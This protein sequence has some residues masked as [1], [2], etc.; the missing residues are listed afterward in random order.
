MVGVFLD[1]IFKCIQ[2][3]EKNEI[4]RWDSLAFFYTVGEIMRFNILK[5]YEFMNC[6]NVWSF[7]SIRYES[8][9]SLQFRDKFKYRLIKL[10]SLS[11]GCMQDK[12]HGKL[13]VDNAEPESIQGKSNLSNKA[14]RNSM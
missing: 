11:L 2:L 4:I 9:F 13:W 5:I 14:L 3:T 10:L 7:S 1:K 8:S 6:V 12:G